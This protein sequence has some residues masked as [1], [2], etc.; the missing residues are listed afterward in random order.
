MVLSLFQIA[1]VNQPL[2]LSALNVG[3]GD[4]IFIQTPEHH[5]ILVDAGEGGQVVD[6][7]GKQLGFFDKT[8]DLFIL[9][10]PHRD[11]YGGFLEALQK[12]EVKNIALTGVSSHD[13]A[14]AD[15]IRR[16]KEMG[17]P[18]VFPDNSRDIHIGPNL[19]LDVLYPFAGQSLVGQE[20]RNKNNTS[21]VM[22]LL[23]RTP[24]RMASLAILTGDAEVE[25][26]R[27]LL[28]S[29]QDL[30]ATLLK[31]GHHGSRTATSDSFLSAVHPKTVV[32]SAGK[33]NSFGHPHPETMEK[34]RG[35]EVRQ[36]MEE[37]SIVWLW[38]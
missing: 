13:A 15:L 31:A 6:E 22:R 21:V 34:L 1:A 18:V 27:E 8:I 19:Y 26:E 2:L 38:L 35:L 36:T 17:I 12:Y 7:L 9:T 29:G 33:D 3:Q 30:S 14:Y 25:E 4:A 5:N 24:E 10:H 23:K 32:I 16:V 11:H 28:L 20:V 37:G